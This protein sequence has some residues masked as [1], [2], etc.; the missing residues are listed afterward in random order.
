MVERNFGR[1]HQ[2]T[3]CKTLSASHHQLSRLSILRI[4]TQTQSAKSINSL[5]RNGKVTM[6]HLASDF[7]VAVTKQYFFTDYATTQ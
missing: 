6:L 3:W 4:S 5:K 7:R 2:V 1:I